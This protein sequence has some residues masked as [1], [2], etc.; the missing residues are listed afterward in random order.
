MYIL[1]RGKSQ[2]PPCLRERDYTQEW[3]RGERYGVLKCAGN[4]MCSLTESSETFVSEFIIKR[5]T[6]LNGHIPLFSLC[7]AIAKSTLQNPVL[8]L[9]TISFC[10]HVEFSL[11]CVFIFLMQKVGGRWLH[12]TKKCF[13]SRMSLG[14]GSAITLRETKEGQLNLR[15]SFELLFRTAPNLGTFLLPEFSYAW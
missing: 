8:Y 7:P 12:F 10:D 3:V 5:A 9:D 13:Q 4:V 14:E 11:N 2:G 6:Y 1:V 15:D